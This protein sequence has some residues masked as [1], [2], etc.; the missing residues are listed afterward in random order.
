MPASSYIS[1]IFAKSPV[2]GIE[3]HMSTAHAAATHLPDFFKAVAASDNAEIRRLY[4][5]IDKAERD[6]DA[7]KKELRL[8][9]PTT[10]FMPVARADVLDLI[11]AQD[12]VANRAK[13]IAGLIAGRRLLMPADTSDMFQEFVQRA[14]DAS[15]QADETV[16][17]LSELFES[18]FRGREVEL[19][20]GMIETLDTI[21]SE[22]DN[23][24]VNL[25]HKIYELEDSLPPVDVMFIYKIIDWIGEL[26]NDAQAV[27]HKIQLILAR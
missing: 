9:L 19:M 18:G 24:E 10:I 16:S 8:R 17:E 23:L 1:R 15:A 25:R 3:N 2:S 12:R 6:A 13:D 22:T 21:E 11:N 4:E 20:E 27:G 14:V 26:A 5:V 7:I